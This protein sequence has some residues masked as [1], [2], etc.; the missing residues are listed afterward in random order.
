MLLFG[1]GDAV[2]VVGA[3]AGGSGVGL[4]DDLD[5]G[6]LSGG[7][8]VFLDLDAGA[9]AQHEDGPGDSSGADE[10]RPP[11]AQSGARG[12]PLNHGIGL[13]KRG[14]VMN[15]EPQRSPGLF[16]RR[17]KIGVAIFVMATLT[18]TLVT[19]AALIRAGFYSDLTMALTLLVT[20][21]VPGILAG[22]VA[23]LSRLIVGERTF[24][25]LQR[26]PPA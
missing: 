20:T 8:A 3:L 6:D 19:L 9:L 25:R 17:A 12:H 10:R 5:R 24:A 22:R 4:A 26:Q 1:G 11:G 15:Q 21:A 13:R 14:D 2:G 7:V 18:V 23:P 16:D